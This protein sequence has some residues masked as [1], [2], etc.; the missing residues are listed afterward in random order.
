MKEVKDELRKNNKSNEKAL[1]QSVIHTMNTDQKKNGY[2]NQANEIQP[3]YKTLWSVSILNLYKRARGSPCKGP[4]G[5]S[6]SPGIDWGYLIKH[7]PDQEEKINTNQCKKRTTNHDNK[8]TSDI[9]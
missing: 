1:C 5:H 7:P 2:L 8:L 3:V 6:Q 9:K 4:P